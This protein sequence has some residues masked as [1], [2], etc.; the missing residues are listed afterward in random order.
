M[1][2]SR[3]SHLRG[4]SAAL[5]DY[6]ERHRAGLRVET[7][8]TED[9]ANFLVKRRLGESRRIRWFRRGANLLLQIGCVVHNCSLG[10]GFDLFEPALSQP[11]PSW[12]EAA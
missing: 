9:T 1:G 6:A 11:H 10:P 4:Q 12:A 8:L 7:S 5:I 3:C 2:A